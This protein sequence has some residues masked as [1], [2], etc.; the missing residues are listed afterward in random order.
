M[1]R[2]SLREDLSSR[3][4]SSL[5][6]RRRG[7]FQTPRER[8]W[9]KERKEKEAVSFIHGKWDLPAFNEPRVKKDYESHNTL[10]VKLL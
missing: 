1:E 2:R 5:R 10:R 7:N 4:C 3:E 9:R 8:R 6:H